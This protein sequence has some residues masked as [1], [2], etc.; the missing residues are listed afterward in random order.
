MKKVRLLNYI[1]IIAVLIFFAVVGIMNTVSYFEKS[2]IEAESEKNIVIAKNNINNIEEY[3]NT[4]M[5]LLNDIFASHNNYEEIIIYLI[6][7]K[8]QV[9]LKENSNSIIGDSYINEWYLQNNGYV[10]DIKKPLNG[11]EVILS[12]ELNDLYELYMANIQLGSL[13]YCTLKDA[14]GVVIMHLAENQIGVDTYNDRGNNDVLLYSQ[15]NLESGY[16]IVDSK[17]WHID[18]QPDGKKIIA[19]ASLIIDD[20]YFVTTNVVDYYEVVNPIKE[21]VQVIIS[22]IFALVVIFI[23]ILIKWYKQKFNLQTTMYEKSLIEQENKMLNY[24]KIKELEIVSSSISHEISNVLTPALI[25]TDILDSKEEKDEN[26]EILN[27]IKSSITQASSYVKQ[28]KDL[29]KYNNFENELENINLNKML[30]DNMEFIKYLIPKNIIFKVDISVDTM[31]IMSNEIGLKQVI[32]NLINNAVAAIGSSNG[33]IK[34]EASSSNKKVIINISDNGVG[35][36]E[37]MKNKI[38]DT[39]YTT[40]E[41]GTGLGLNIC[42]KIIENQGGNITFISEINKGST[43]TIIFENYE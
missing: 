17:W 6:D 16:E 30:K 1:I 7:Q 29:K 38:F 13:G 35:I 11:Y 9:I 41:D 2:L 8:E 39:F 36:S 4:K 40:K 10:L 23:I 22:I 37:E 18:N 14:N 27:E 3:I 33:E 20:H 25:Y 26:K 28:L 31:N 19:F 32:I 21:V 5:N 12:I 15:Y 42:K 43:F 34:L 24:A